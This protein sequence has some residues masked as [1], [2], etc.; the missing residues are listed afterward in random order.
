M[1]H[2]T[3]WQLPELGA[4][5]KPT[6][7]R[8]QM[9]ALLVATSFMTWFNRI[10]MTVAYDE[11]ISQE[12][13]YGITPT[14]MGTVYSALLI[15]YT[16]FMTP[17][18][19]F[20]DRFGP[21]LALVVMGLGSALF[22]AATGAAGFPAFVGG[23]LLVVLLIIRSSMGVVMAPVYPASSRI[24]AHWLPPNQRA[25]ANG[26]VQGAAALGIACTF[27]LFGRLIDWIDWP[28]AFLVTGAVTGFVALVWFA[29]ATNVPAQHGRVNVAERSLIDPPAHGGAPRGAHPVVSHLAASAESPD[30]PARPAPLWRNRSLIMLTLSYAAVGYVEYLFFHWLHY[31]FENVLH[32]GK[33]ESRIY[34]AVPTLAMAAGMVLGGW[35]ADHLRRR[36]GAGRGRGIVPVSGLL[37]G[38]ML[39]IAGLVA[40]ETAWVV[41]WFALALAAV[42]ATEAP[43]W[44]MATELGGQRGG[45]AAAICNTGGNALGLL[46]PQITPLISAAIIRQFG[47]GEVAGWKWAIS[48]SSVIAMV[49]AVLWLWITPPE[50]ADGRSASS[51]Y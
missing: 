25:W 26:L 22:G 29:Y 45:T 39:V 10:S 27:P 43:V 12:P 5:A 37:I 51:M 31:Y 35:V 14:E 23:T 6:W 32:L 19:W 44:T 47:L 15:A 20:I 38:A 50:G 1:N 40:D 46:A 4:L 49:G 16:I 42:G 2:S 41:L 13:H 34:A 33:S 9:V 7:V 17:G 11:R 48:L 28:S 36:L 24:V 30:V 21:W 3:S 8:W 18:G